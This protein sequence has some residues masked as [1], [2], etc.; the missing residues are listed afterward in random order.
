MKYLSDKFPEALVSPFLQEVSFTS[1]YAHAF[2]LTV[3]GLHSQILK[4]FP[5]MHSYNCQ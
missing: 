1:L 5:S 2:K 4:S 3:L